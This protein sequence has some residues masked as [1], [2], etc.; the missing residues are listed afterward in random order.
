MKTTLTIISERPY[1]LGPNHEPY[2]VLPKGGT[3]PFSCANCTHLFRK[4]GTYRC[5]SREFVQFNG[6]STLRDAQGNPLDDPS[7]AC[8]DWFAPKETL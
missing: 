5:G 8:S 7:R 1:S 4:A 2:M 6:D 3:G